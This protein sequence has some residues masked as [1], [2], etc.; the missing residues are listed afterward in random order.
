MRVPGAGGTSEPDPRPPHGCSS[1]ADPLGRNRNLSLLAPLA[2]HADPGAG[3]AGGHLGAEMASAVSSPHFPSVRPRSSEP[4]RFL[5]SERCRLH[6]MAEARE[7]EPKKWAISPRPHS[8]KVASGPTFLNLAGAGGDGCSILKSHCS[9]TLFPWVRAW[10]RSGE[11]NLAG[12]LG[13]MEAG[14]SS[15]CS[16]LPGPGSRMK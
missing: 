3:G 15:H 8:R 1:W 2:L 11:Q 12:G 10:V 14:R 5:S 16:P 7:R 6:S 9:K 13:E 4:L